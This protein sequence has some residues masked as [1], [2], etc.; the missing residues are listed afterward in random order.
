MLGSST[1][2]GTILCWVIGDRSSEGCVCRFFGVYSPE[3]P[4]GHSAN[5][6]LT[7]F[8][9]VGFEGFAQRFEYGEGRELVP[10]PSRQNS[11]ENATRRTK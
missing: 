10:L 2:A 3:C 1:L 6:A 11:Y 5:F 9:W 8:P 4:E 7:A